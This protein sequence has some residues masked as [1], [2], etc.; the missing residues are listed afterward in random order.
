MCGVIPI[1]IGRTVHS[2]LDKLRVP[3]AC[4]ARVEPGRGHALAWAQAAMC[5]VERRVFVN[6]LPTK[7]RSATQLHKA[8]P[9]KINQDMAA[10]R[11]DPQARKTWAA[12]GFF[13][14]YRNAASAEWSKL[15]KRHGSC[16]ED[17][18]VS[19]KEDDSPTP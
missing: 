3:P 6:F 2:P 14:A 12:G 5:E 15:Q 8:I 19:C 1:A 9:L 17:N 11:S 7:T 13:A 16:H 18:A 10:A 4:G